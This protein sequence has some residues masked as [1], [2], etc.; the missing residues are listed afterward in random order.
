MKDILTMMRAAPFREKFL[1]FI[2]VYRENILNSKLISINGQTVFAVQAPK[3][4]GKTTLLQ[5]F[6]HYID[7]EK[8]LKYHTLF[9]HL[10]RFN[11]LGDIPPVIGL[12]NFN[13]L[14]NKIPN[15]PSGINAMRT[16]DQIN[17]LNSYRNGWNGNVGI[18]LVDECP[19]I[20]LLHHIDPQAVPEVFFP[21]TACFRY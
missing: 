11:E 3:G 4:Y 17:F 9:D 8:E 7:C 13:S 2:S 6:T 10:R 20:G 18:I 21:N 12:D 16:I 15:T 5:E 19:L 14:Y 1:S